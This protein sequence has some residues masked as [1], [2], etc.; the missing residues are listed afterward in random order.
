MFKITILK[1]NKVGKSYFWRFF[2][3]NDVTM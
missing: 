1:I 3:S 2:S